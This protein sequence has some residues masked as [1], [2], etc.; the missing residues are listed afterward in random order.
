MLFNPLTDLQLITTVLVPPGDQLSATTTLG[1]NPTRYN[2]NA[3]AMFPISC[4]FTHTSD[5]FTVDFY[6]D[7]VVISDGNLPDTTLTPTELDLLPATFERT[8]QLEFL[9]FQAVHDGV[10][11]CSASTTDT[12]EVLSSDMYLYGSGKFA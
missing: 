10:Y 12:M 11:H 2:L 9:N 3:G 5:A 6:E 4:T 8:L 7:G 1:N